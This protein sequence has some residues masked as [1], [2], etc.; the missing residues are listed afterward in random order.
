MIYNFKITS[1]ES[2][3]FILKLA[4]DGKSTFFDLHS[5]IQKFTGIERYNLASF[6]LSEN[7]G[8]K[9]RE[10]SMLDIGVNG[11][12]YF[13][14][15][16]T[17]LWELIKSDGQKLLYTYDFINDKSFIIELTEIDMVKNLEE[18]LIAQK[19]GDSPLQVLNEE[20]DHHA[21][22]NVQEEEV[23]MDFGILDDYNELFGEMEDF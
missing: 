8:I 22:A 23:F 13:I 1:Q 10:I 6:F 21:S 19:E 5:A 16:K 2:E 17:A 3:N 4:L 14:M 11:G 12:A 9:T 15:Q 18:P 20:N 7:G